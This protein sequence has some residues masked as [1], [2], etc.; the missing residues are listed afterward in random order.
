MRVEG[1]SYPHPHHPPGAFRFG[2]HQPPQALGQ[3]ALVGVLCQIRPVQ[4][5]RG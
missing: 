5:H 4:I 3:L 1:Y 2:L